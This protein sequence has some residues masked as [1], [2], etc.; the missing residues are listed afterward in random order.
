MQ[1]TVEGK[2][3]FVHR[4]RDM[5]SIMKEYT[6][7]NANKILEDF[8]GVIQSAVDTLMTQ[9]EAVYIKHYDP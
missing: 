4:V 5:I 9:F 2:G 1:V 8:N 7:K 3:F 6:V